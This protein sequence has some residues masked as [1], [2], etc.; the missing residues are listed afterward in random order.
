MIL[1]D[2]SDGKGKLTI[3]GGH[4]YKGQLKN[5]MMHGRGELEWPD[6]TKYIGQFVDNTLYGR[7]CYMWYVF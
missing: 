3:A 7:G 4:T 6:G 5:G 2:I 1:G